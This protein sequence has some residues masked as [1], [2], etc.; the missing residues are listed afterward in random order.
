[1]PKHPQM[2][3]IA[4]RTLNT[5]EVFKQ[6]KKKA[7]DCVRQATEAVSEPFF[8]TIQLLLMKSVGLSSDKPNLL[9]SPAAQ[10]QKLRRLSSSNNHYNFM[11]HKCGRKETFG[12]ILGRHS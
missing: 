2:I 1:M 5:R 10:H 7:N 11:V 9:R 12:A 3:I 8:Y 4:A 6:Q